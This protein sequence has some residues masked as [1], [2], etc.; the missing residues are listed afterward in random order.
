M[1]NDQRQKQIAEQNG[2][3]SVYISGL[4]TLQMQ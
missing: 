1:H 4:E 3:D 2:I